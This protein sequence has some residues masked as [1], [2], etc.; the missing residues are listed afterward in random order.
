M[1]RTIWAEVGS[2]PTTKR[3]KLA[4][5]AR[6]DRSKFM[7]RALSFFERHVSVRESNTNE[8]GDDTRNGLELT[9]FN[10]AGRVAGS[11]QEF[12]HAII[13]DSAHDPET[14]IA[15]PLLVRRLLAQDF[16]AVTALHE[17]SE[18]CFGDHIWCF[19]FPIHSSGHTLL[20]EMHDH[21]PTVDK[22][23]IQ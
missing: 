8:E 11:D 17:F 21:L 18:S 4:A 12:F 3:E 10:V 13:T 1:T 5:S 19:N 16:C 2:A 9:D 15:R 6:V 20:V 7:D 23:D 22:R 14:V